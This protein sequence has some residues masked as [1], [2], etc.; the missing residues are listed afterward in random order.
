L[1]FIDAGTRI[2]RS[3]MVTP[4]APF[5]FITN[6]LPVCVVVTTVWPG[7]APTISRSSLSPE[8]TA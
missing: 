2:V 7:P 4:R 8:R 5:R 1:S 3:R 6:W